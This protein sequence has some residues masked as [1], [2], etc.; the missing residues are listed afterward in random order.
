M[1][2][3]AF[4]RRHLAWLLQTREQ[5]KRAH[6]DAERNKNAR[7]A[8]LCETQI[9]G[10]DHLIRRCEMFLIEERAAV[11]RSSRARIP[12]EKGSV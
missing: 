11:E 4:M 1:D 3:I 6:E 9:G 2:T 5:W 12:T 10:L 8:R 7:V